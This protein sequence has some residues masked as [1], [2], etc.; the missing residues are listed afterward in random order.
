MKRPP[1]P[2]CPCGGILR[3]KQERAAKTCWMCQLAAQQQ[4][5]AAAKRAGPNGTT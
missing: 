5:D 3:S 2:R 1:H 4:R